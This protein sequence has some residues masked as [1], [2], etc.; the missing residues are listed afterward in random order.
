MYPLHIADNTDNNTTWG[1]M[2]SAQ[3]THVRT[4]AMIKI[5]TRLCNTTRYTVY[6][7]QITT[8][9]I[10]LHGDPYEVHK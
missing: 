8:L 5:T 4:N 2:R 1:P 3:V 6:T 10:T 7:W 9:I